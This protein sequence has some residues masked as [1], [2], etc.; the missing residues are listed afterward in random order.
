MLQFSDDSGEQLAAARFP[1]LHTLRLEHCKLEGAAAGIGAAHLPALSSL[2][3][4][5]C[6]FYARARGRIPRGASTLVK[7]GAHRWP[8]L[9][10]LV[11]TKCSLANGSA[12]AVAAEPWPALTELDLSDNEFKG[13]GGGGC[14]SGRRMAPAPAAAPPRPTLNPGGSSADSRCLPSPALPE[15]VPRLR[16]A[17]RGPRKRTPATAGPSHIPLAGRRPCGHGTVRP[18]ACLEV[19]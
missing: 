12:A 5:S 3:V 16:N 11:L 10:K 14:S 13:K 4:T 7:G 6:A 17:R 19:Q 2:V 18:A 8:R 9:Q 15:P 1:S